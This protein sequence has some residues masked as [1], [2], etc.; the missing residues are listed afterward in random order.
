MK[1]FIILTTILFLNSCNV[2]KTIT[3]GDTNI[4]DDFFNRDNNQENT[5]DE[6]HTNIVCPSG[7]IEVSGN[8]SLGT[9][10]F[11]V[12]K[13]E[14]KDN[15]GTPISQE[16]GIPWG[17]ITAPNSLAACETMSE[18]GFSGQFT[19]ISNPEWLTIARDIEN[20]SSNWSGGSVGSGHIPRG[21][22]DNAP[23][24][25]LSI[26]NN[27]D[28]YDGTGNNSAEGAGAGWEQKRTHILSNGKEIWDL[29]GNASEWVD[30][31]INTSGFQIAPTDEPSGWNELSVNPTGS[32]LLDDYKPDNDTYSSSNSFGKW[33]GGSGGTP[34]RGG[35]YTNLTNAGVFTLLIS[36]AITASTPNTS[37]RCVYRP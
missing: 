24:N 8:S 19:L 9:N 25:T 22:S 30:W 34:L 23:A 29:A 13:Y 20:N 12:M 32:L 7:F 15:S 37:F 10:D 26:S 14:A 33:A 35:G 36:I 27:L 16:S 31:D 17:N 6:D 21:H 3:D 1:I 18:S 5:N 11:C 28:P 2:L 4:N